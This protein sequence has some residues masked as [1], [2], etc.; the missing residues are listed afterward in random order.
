MSPLPWRVRFAPHRGTEHPTNIRITI[1]ATHRDF[2]PAD[3]RAVADRLHD[4]A[5]RIENDERNDA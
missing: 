5:D 1:G 3:A 2:P 4:L